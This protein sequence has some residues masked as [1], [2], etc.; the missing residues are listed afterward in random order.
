METKRTFKEKWANFK[1]CVL[2]LS[3]G[4]KIAWLGLSYLTTFILG[5]V[6][7]YVA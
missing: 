5:A 2:D 7:A 4:E 6:I 1:Y 3:K